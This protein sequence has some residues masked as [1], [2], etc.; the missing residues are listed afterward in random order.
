MSNL[1]IRCVLYSQVPNP[2]GGEREIIINVAEYGVNVHT[3]KSARRNF[4][5]LTKRT[6]A[7]L[8][9]WSVRIERVPPQGTR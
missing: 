5:A 7:T 3:E 6:R 8:Q 2:N 9:G 1:N 4:L